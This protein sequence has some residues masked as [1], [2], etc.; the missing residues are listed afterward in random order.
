MA[1]ER[2]DPS[3]TRQLAAQMVLEARQPTV[4]NFQFGIGFVMCVASLVVFA[5]LLLL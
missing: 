5:W 2:L 1:L 3:E 4:T